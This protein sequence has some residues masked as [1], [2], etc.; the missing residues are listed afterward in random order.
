MAETSPEACLV[1]T[2]VPV[3]MAPEST[4]EADR[5]TK[6]QSPAQRL[7]AR[8]CPLSSVPEQAVPE[9]VNEHHD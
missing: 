9:R 2:E 8:C 3:R 4:A 6:H 5:A 7:K 1:P